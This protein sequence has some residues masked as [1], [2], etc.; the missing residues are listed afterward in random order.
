VSRRAEQNIRYCRM[1]RVS[2]YQDIPGRP[3]ACSS[4][5]L[6]LFFLPCI[7]RQKP[8]HWD[9]RPGTLI[10]Q[11]TRA[12]EAGSSR[13]FRA[14]EEGRWRKSRGQISHTLVYPG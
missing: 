5:P 10:G 2:E 1:A 8:E 4:N 3:F 11:P 13:E 14:E 9:A 6:R 7:K 12:V